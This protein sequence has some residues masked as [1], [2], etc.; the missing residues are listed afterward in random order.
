MAKY[1]MDFLSVL[2]MVRKKRPAVFPNNGFVAQLHL[3]HKMNFGVDIAHPE[4]VNYYQ[5]YKTK[6]GKV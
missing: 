5:V 6:K 1:K 2:A 3:F 4:Y